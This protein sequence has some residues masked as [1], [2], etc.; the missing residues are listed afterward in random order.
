MSS[1]SPIIC[2]YGITVTWPSFRI[3]ISIKTESQ[4]RIGIG[5]KY[6]KSRQE[7]CNF[8]LSKTTRI[9]TVRKLQKVLHVV[10][11]FCLCC[12]M[13]LVSKPLQKEIGRI[14]FLNFYDMQEIL[15]ERSYKKHLNNSSGG[16]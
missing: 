10:H 1:H 13:I 16:R 14:L 8:T 9:Y 15:I 7:P 6:T 2:H 5:I 3:W 4:L 11:R 12:S